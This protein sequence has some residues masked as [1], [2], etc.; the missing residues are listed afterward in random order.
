MGV[1]RGAKKTKG[2]RSGANWSAKRKK[3]GVQ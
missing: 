2:A 1:N 3:L